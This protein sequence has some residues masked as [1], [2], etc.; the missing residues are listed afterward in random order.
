MAS[1]VGAP[2]GSARR[3]VNG[4]VE[5]GGVVCYPVVND[6]V[7]IAARGSVVNDAVFV[8]AFA[9]DRRL[10][11]WFCRPVGAFVLLGRGCRGFL[12]PRLW[13]VAALRLKARAVGRGGGRPGHAT[14]KQT[15]HRNLTRSRSGVG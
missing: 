11:D 4:P 3:P 12:H 15:S 9:F 13:A 2:A 6:G 1:N 10:L 14:F 8:A 5:G 7:S